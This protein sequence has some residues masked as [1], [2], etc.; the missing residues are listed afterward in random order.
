[1]TISKSKISIMEDWSKMVN[2]RSDIKEENLITDN[3]LKK[4]IITDPILKKIPYLTLALTQ[5]CPFR[6]I[7]CGNGGEVTISRKKEFDINSFKKVV[8]VAINL[9]IQK[10][11]L[12][13]G[14]PFAYRHI[15]D[16]ISYILAKNK[17]LLINTN[18]LLIDRYIDDLIK[19]KNLDKLHIALSLHTLNESMFNKLSSTKKYFRKTMKNIELLLKYNLLMRI[20]MVVTKYNKNEIK[21]MILFCCKKNIDLKLQEV[22]SVPSPYNKWG[23]LH[24]PFKKIEAELERMSEKRYFHDYAKNHG[25]P[26][27][28]YK[29]NN[30]FVTLK[31]LHQGSRYN[32]ERL[33]N[34]CEYFPYHEGLY[35]IQVLP[36]LRI[37]T[38]RWNAFGHGSINAFKTDLKLAIKIFREA[39]HMS[40]I[41]QIKN[42]APLEKEQAFGLLIKPSL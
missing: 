27:L 36:D 22:T 19:L 5:K 8:D 29:I 13:G 4:G 2:H 30:I 17:Y 28:I 15:I 7:F 33:C 41:N 32:I 38:C 12:T 34:K 21:D 37:A 39:K 10:F 3:N 26:V 6:C 42:M 24:Y 25:I 1:M 31:S 20:N 23:N 40:H 35:D 11:R 9:G 14:E 16:A 18:G